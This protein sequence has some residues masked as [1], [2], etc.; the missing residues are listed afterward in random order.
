MFVRY[1]RNE[2]KLFFNYFQ[3]PLFIYSQYN[4]NLNLVFE[5]INTP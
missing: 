4:R 5:L 2:L 3:E 1:G